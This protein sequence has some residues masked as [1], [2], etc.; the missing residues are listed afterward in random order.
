ML[1]TST[2]VLNTALNKTLGFCKAGSKS[3]CFPP[4]FP[5]RLC[6]GSCGSQCSPLGLGVQP[7]YVSSETPAAPGLVRTPGH[8]KWSPSPSL[9]S[10]RRGVKVR[11][12][13]CPPA[14]LGAQ[15]HSPHLCPHPSPKLQLCKAVGALLCPTGPL[16]GRPGYLGQKRESQGH[17]PR[18][19]CWIWISGTRISIDLEKG[20][21]S[22]QGPL[23]LQWRLTCQRL[24]VGISHNAL[25]E[26]TSMGI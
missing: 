2:R 15:D 20:P 23:W 14:C 6:C 8:T 13:S 5:A 16:E 21:H 12:R 3:E 17:L 26:P 22:H 18:P 4:P 11:G 24:K 9:N 19:H 25:C 10:Q 7:K 1:V